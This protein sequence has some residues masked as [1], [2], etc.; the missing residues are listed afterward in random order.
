MAELEQ[1]RAEM[2]SLKNPQLAEN[3]KKYLKSPYSFYGIRVPELRKIA[4]KYKDIDIQKAYNLFDNL[5]TSNNH[6]EMNMALFLMQN[7]KKQYTLEV[8]RFLMDEKRLEKL[9]TW[10]HV[11]AL[12]GGTLGY[13]L[14]DNP[15]LQSELKQ[16]SISRNPWLRR[17][18]I[19]SQGSLIKKGKIQFTFLLAEKLVYDEDIYVQKGTG[20]MIREAGKKNHAQAEQFIL[21]HKNMK[22]AA[23]SYATEK[24]PEVKKL[25]KEKL[26]QEKLHGKQKMFDDKDNSNSSQ[27]IQQKKPKLT[28]ELNK[29]KHFRN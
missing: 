8:W 22:P 19:V 13:I 23:L 5:W 29:I 18:S 24:M 21:I 2:H 25:I 17:V 15:H 9:K 4:K 1:I 7:Y 16:L 28:S 3:Y 6:D 27:E 26:K 20:W 11:D 14:L 12:C 10:D